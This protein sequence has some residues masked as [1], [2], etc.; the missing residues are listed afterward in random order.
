MPFPAKATP[1]LSD[2]DKFRF[3]ASLSIGEIDQ[4]WKC[5]GDDRA[6]GYGHATFKD[7]KHYLHRIAWA[8]FIGPVAKGVNVL[9]KCDIPSCCNP[10]H[11]FL[12]THTDN[13]RDK[14]FKGRGNYPIGKKHHAVIHPEEMARGENN[15]S[16]ILKE[17][18]V[19]E[20]RALKSSGN[21]FNRELALM[22]GVSSGTIK[23]ISRRKTWTHI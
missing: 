23:S 18:Q 3:C 16:A 20:I 19:L 12:G 9:H 14:V 22:F 1:I 6:G 8:T 5:N 13:M 15:G 10:T 21:Y 4:C 11:L 7:E 2:K 17:S